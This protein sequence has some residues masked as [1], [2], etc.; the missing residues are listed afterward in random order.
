LFVLFTDSCTQ[1]G[2]HLVDDFTHVTEFKSYLLER[3]SRNTDH[4]LLQV[5][6]FNDDFFLYRAVW[7]Q[8]LRQSGKKAGKADEQQGVG[9]V[10]HGMGIGYLARHLGGHP[11][12]AGEFW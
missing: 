1:G 4:I 12:F 8:F 5:E 11:C 3:H 9:H 2:K 6:R 10:K 7:H